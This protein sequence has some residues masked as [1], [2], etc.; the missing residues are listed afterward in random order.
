MH[1][2][3]KNVQ[4]RGFDN[5]LVIFRNNL[6]ISIFSLQKMNINFIACLRMTLRATQSLFS[7][8]Q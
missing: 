6:I 8:I 5:D 1:F 3:N 2:V 4:I 7:L